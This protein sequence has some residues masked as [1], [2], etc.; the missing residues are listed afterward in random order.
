MSLLFAKAFDDSRASIRLA[1]SGYGPQACVL[2]MQVYESALNAITVRGSEEL[3]STLLD[4]VGQSANVLARS[5]NV[6]RFT[7]KDREVIEQARAIQPKGGWPTLEDR[8]NGLPGEIRSKYQ[9]ALPLSISYS[10]WQLSNLTSRIGEME[11]P[12]WTLSIGR[13]DQD[14][15]L[16]LR[17]VSDFFFDL[18]LAVAE[19]FG[20]PVD[21]L[22]N[23]QKRA[24]KTF[25]E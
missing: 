6:D 19:F 16:A 20:R 4:T 11:N 8:V 10:D 18:T 17:I 24:I 23:W 13:S 2:A 14:V 21:Q 25:S 1:K 15:R 3:A 7:G 22:S 9:A 12:E 5:L